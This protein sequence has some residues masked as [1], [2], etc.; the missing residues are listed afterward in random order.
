MIYF[1][2]WMPY[3]Q[4]VKSFPFFSPMNIYSNQHFFQMS[5]YTDRCISIEKIPKRRATVFN[6]YRY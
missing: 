3:C 2:R 6:F 4:T 5:L 1:V